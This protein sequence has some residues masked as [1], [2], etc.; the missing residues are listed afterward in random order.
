MCIHADAFFSI[1]RKYSLYDTTIED[2]N[3][4]LNLADKW[5]FN[6]VKDLAVRELQKK[7][8]LDLVSKMAL[9]QTYKVDPRHLI[10]LYAQL[11]ERDTPITLNEARIL[12]IETTVLINST[13]EQL[14][15]DP[16]NEGR[17][18]LP[19]GL[20]EGD[21]FRALELGL[22]LE[23]GSTAKFRE[24][25]SFSAPTCTFPLLYLSILD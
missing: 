14:R 10:P 15:A 2:W 9:Y 13:R 20:E 3:I 18:P 1:D 19:A 7:P 16:S 22:G 11:C 8:D 21:V 23:Q 5:E 4:I 6:E 25:N 12:G 17:S 24:E